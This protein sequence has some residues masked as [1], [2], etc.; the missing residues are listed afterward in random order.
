MGLVVIG[1][2]LWLIDVRGASRG[3]AP[4]AANGNQRS[5]SRDRAHVLRDKPAIA[6]P[7]PTEGARNGTRLVRLQ[8]AISVTLDPFLVPAPY[9][10]RVDQSDEGRGV[11]QP[12]EGRCAE[13]HTRNAAEIR[14]EAYSLAWCDD[15]VTPAGPAGCAEFF[16]H[17]DFATPAQV[18]EGQL[19][20]A[21]QRN[22]RLTEMLT[23]QSEWPVGGAAANGTP[24]AEGAPEM[25]Q[26]APTNQT[27]VRET[28]QISKALLQEK[29]HT[30]VWFLYKA[31]C[32][33]RVHDES[34]YAPFVELL[35]IGADIEV[36]AGG[37][38]AQSQ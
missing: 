1:V 23:E 10:Y 13:G 5:K 2:A 3:V 20:E 38:G 8:C 9:T 22:L 34:E 25:V 19:A 37:G 24:P 12:D 16:L 30:A 21:T 18:W 29:V 6:K 36:A 4:Q 27:D 32:A 31:N 35:R 15:S 17:G 26:H 11:D 28:E 14:L 33:M 7:Q